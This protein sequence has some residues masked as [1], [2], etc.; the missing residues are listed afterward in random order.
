MLSTDNTSGSYLA[1]N[2]IVWYATVDAVV[3]PFPESITTPYTIVLSWQ[4]NIVV[5]CCFVAIPQFFESIIF[6][7]MNFWCCFGL[8]WSLIIFMEVALFLQLVKKKSPPISNKSDNSICHFHWCLLLVLQRLLNVM[9][10]EMA[11]VRKRSIS[12]TNS[13]AKR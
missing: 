9:P 7:L 5:Q 11:E 3:H 8:F 1:T 10:L 6:C 12:P 2:F 13:E 4:W